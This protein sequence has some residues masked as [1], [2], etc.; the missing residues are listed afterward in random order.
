[1]FDALIMVAQIDCRGREKDLMERIR[2]DRVSPMF[3]IR[4]TELAN[5]AAIPGKNYARLYGLL[6]QLFTMT[7][8]WNIVG[9]DNSVEW[10]MKAHFLSSLGYG[11]GSKQGLIRVAFDPAILEICLE[12]SQW[13]SLS[14]QTMHGLG[15]GASYSLYQNVWRYS[16]TA[17]KVTAALPTAT[18]IKLLVGVSR[19]VKE[20]NGETIVEYGDFKRRVLLDAINRVNEVPALAYKIVLKEHRSGNRISRLQFKFVEKESISLGLPLTWPED[21]LK[22]LEG[23]GYQQ[24][25]IEDLSEGFSYEVVAEAIVRLKASEG[26]LRAQG[27]TV[28]ARKPYFEGILRNLHSGGKADAADDERIAEEIRQ[29]E[30]KLANEVRQERLKESFQNHQKELFVSWLFSVPDEVRAEL[31][32]SFMSSSD[33]TAPEKHL[34]AKGLRPAN[35][36]A[37]AV[38]RIWLAKTRPE[39]FDQ[40][41]TNPEDRSFDAWMAWRLDNLE[42]SSR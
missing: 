28:T 39:L 16:G 29:Q 7:L 38:L 30:A 22:V 14:L 27:K 36:S 41:F 34:L 33:T 12:P 10:S 35:T 15:T 3:E 20:E 6:D 11:K 17:A 5:L 40:I 23:I 21:V 2:N 25:E 19:Y 9:E 18:W 8:D 26:R 1:L 24:R 31:E 32:E 4:V 42:A 37:T 13:A